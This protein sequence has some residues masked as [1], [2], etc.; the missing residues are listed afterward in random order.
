M[1]ISVCRI[2]DSTKCQDNAAMA[3]LTATRTA[4]RLHPTSPV[5]ALL[6]IRN[7]GQCQR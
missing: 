1:R 6:R 4:N 2:G 7:T 5:R 3:T